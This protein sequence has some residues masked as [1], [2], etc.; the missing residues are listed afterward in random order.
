M[1]TVQYSCPPPGQTSPS[2]CTCT[3]GKSGLFLRLPGMRE[4]SH[5]VGLVWFGTCL[6]K[7][8]PARGRSGL[9]WHYT[10]EEGGQPGGGL[11]WFG[12][13]LGLTHSLGPLQR[14]ASQG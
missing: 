14:E 1:Y 8:R 9:V 2:P 7:G 4:I 5:V 3:W 11:V 13:Y 6:G 10:W 12:A